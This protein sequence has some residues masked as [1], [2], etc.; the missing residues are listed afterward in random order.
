[1]LGIG[2]AESLVLVVITLACALPALAGVAMFVMTI[3]D[4]ARGQGRWGINFKGASCPQCKQAA[5][6]IRVPKTVGQ[7]LWGGWTCER[8]QLEIDKWGKPIRDR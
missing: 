6:T 3:V 2:V 7:A 4:T 5:P 8:C 1:M